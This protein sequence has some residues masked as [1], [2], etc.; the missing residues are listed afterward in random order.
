VPLR[1]DECILV[2]GKWDDPNAFIF[3]AYATEPMTAPEASQAIYNYELALNEF[4]A[5]G[6]LPDGLGMGTKHPLVAVICNNDPK[7]AA[8]VTDFYG[9]SLHHLVDDLGVSAIVADLSPDQLKT[10]FQTTVNE[11]KSV[12]FLNP[13]AAN[14]DLLNLA[15]NGLVWSMLG[16][17]KDLA[18]GYVD[19]VHRIEKYIRARSDAGTTPL[20]VAVVRSDDASEVDHQLLTELYGAVLPKLSFNADSAINQSG[21]NYREFPI[22]TDAGTPTPSDVAD[23]INDYAPHIVISMTGTDFTSIQS[24]SKPEGVAHR[25]VTFVKGGADRMPWVQHEYPF[26][27]FSPINAAATSDFSAL[28]L[29]S[30]ALDYRVIY[31]RFLGINVAGAEDRDVLAEYQKRLRF[32]QPLATDGFENYYDA[33]YY[34]A[35]AAY[36]AGVVSIDGSRISAGMS[37]LNS[38]VPLKV[39]PM[40]VTI[41]GGMN[42]L[43]AQVFNELKTHGSVQ[44]I[45]ASGSGFDVTHGVRIDKAGLYCFQYN[46]GST[47]I[48]HQPAEIFDAFLQKW[49]VLASCAPGL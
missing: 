12:F 31:Q 35:Y 19:L 48:S 5:V 21:G 46:T 16:P 20:R 10:A 11:G 18:D 37:S 36:A 43:I 30:T 34:L 27:V 9:K 1:T 15:D 28:L 47:P 23:A 13:G 42:Q 38:G 7:Q 49:T 39:G 44:L 29:S 33:I 17:P 4:N 32:Y 45:G 8:L 2:R 26:F 22:N 40:E 25:M 3:G 41:D 14:N 24:P 6:G